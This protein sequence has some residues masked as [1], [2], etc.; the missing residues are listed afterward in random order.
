V[1]M[2]PSFGIDLFMYRVED[3]DFNSGTV[4]GRFFKEGKV[5]N[6]TVPV[7]KLTDNRVLNK[8]N[9]GLHEF[10]EKLAPLSYCPRA[11][12]NISK[13]KQ[14]RLYC[15]NPE[16]RFEA[17]VIPTIE[18]GV[19]QEL[20]AAFGQLKT[21]TIILK[22][23]HGKMGRDI[24]KITQL[25]G[26]NAY[27][28]SKEGQTSQLR[29][30]ELSRFFEEQSLIVPLVQPCVNSRAQS[31]GGAPFDIRIRVQRINSTKYM[32]DIYPRINANASA[33][34]SNIHRGGFSM[35]LDAF[36]HLEY[37]EQATEVKEKL[38]DLARHFPRYFQQFLERPFFDL[39]IDVGVDRREDG[40][41]QPKIFEVN[42][43]PG[44]SGYLGERTGINSVFA[45]LEYYCYL[46]NRFIDDT[47]PDYVGLTAQDRVV[48]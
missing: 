35:P 12:V 27:E 10:F 13:I 23:A 41:L 30:E 1:Y 7:P 28:V 6:K 48:K 45:T 9:A 11:R 19:A 14:Y 26:G 25:D 29:R 31:M 16:P 44:G 3:V 33:I 2:A 32:A 34:A 37:G 22:S 39:G 46:W 5:V 18:I 38:D 47:H 40:S 21:G 15:E 24:S 36:L 4:N 17:Y 20:E 42:G 43:L 8:R